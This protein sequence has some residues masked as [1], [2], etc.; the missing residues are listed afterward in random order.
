MEY[1]WPDTH[2][3]SKNN[4]VCIFMGT[5]D[6][7][8]DIPLGDINDMYPQNKTVCGALNY[9][10]T[11]IR[12]DNTACNIIGILPLNRKRGTKEN[13]FAYGTINNA[14]YTLNDLNIKINE[15][16]KKYCCNVIDNT[17]SP[18]NKYSINN[19]LNDGLHPNEYGIDI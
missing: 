6:Y 8:N 11:K 17:F 19:L 7:G 10:L 18:I 3:F 14:G 5:N 13:N 9:I 1:Q 4:F 2:D 16:Y 15:I 12:N